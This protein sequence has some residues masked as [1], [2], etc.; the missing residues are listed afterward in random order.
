MMI[1]HKAHLGIATALWAMVGL[2]LLTAGLF[3]LFGDIGIGVPSMVTS[4]AALAVGA[5][6][7]S[8]V[9]P[10]IAKK[11]KDRILALPEASP[12][13]MTFNAKSWLLVLSMILLGRLIRFAGTPHFVVGG[14]YMAVGIA[15]LLG[16]TCYLKNAAEAEA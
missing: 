14:I 16:S 11:N 9:L 10:K 13:Y 3:F 2:G 15:L 8:V 1:S 6:K 12:F 7:G 5:F 4:I